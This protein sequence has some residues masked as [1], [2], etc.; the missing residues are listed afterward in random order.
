M[1]RTKKV[2]SAGRFGARYGR[3]IRARIKN[4][5]TVKKHDCP[6]CHKP[7]MKREAAGIWKC[8]K[9]STKM[10]GKAYRP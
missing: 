8:T 1:G 3:K 2:G 9:C 5:E 6:S 7:G 4:T 10:A